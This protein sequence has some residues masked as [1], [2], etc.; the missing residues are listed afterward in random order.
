MY[1]FANIFSQSVGHLLVPLALSFA[2]Q[3]FLILIES[4]L[5]IVS[6]TEH[7]FSVYLKCLCHIH[8]H[9]TFFML[10]SRSFM[11]LPLTFRFLTHFEI[12][13]EV[14]MSMS[15][16][17][18]CMCMSTC[19]SII[20]WKDYLCCTVLPLLFCHRSGDCGSTTELYSVPLIYLPFFSHNTVLIIIALQ[21][22]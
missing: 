5:F 2:G 9:L 15:K 11:L 6:F 21:K 8:V 17:I 4:S 14:I 3:N 19:S 18:F 20:C 10:S 16:L 12:F 22:F 13:V 1:V 7:V